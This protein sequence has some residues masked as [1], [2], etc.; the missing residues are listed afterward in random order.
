MAK[1]TKISRRRG[2]VILYIE[3]KNGIVDISEDEYDEWIKNNKDLLINNDV[4]EK[5]NNLP[6]ELRK[7]WKK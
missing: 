1:D 3:T 2:K 4:K 6:I 5:E 7:K